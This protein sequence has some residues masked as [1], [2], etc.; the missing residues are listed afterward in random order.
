MIGRLIWRSAGRWLSLTARKSSTCPTSPS[1]LHI[2]ASK[3]AVESLKLVSYPSRGCL[4]PLRGRFTL[5]RS[6]RR[7]RK[8]LLLSLNCSLGRQY[9]QSSF[10]RVPRRALHEGEVGHDGSRLHR[11]RLTPSRRREEFLNHGL[12]DII[13]LKHQNVY[14]D[15][16]ELKD[17][18]DSGEQRVRRATQ[19]KLNSADSLPRSACTLGGNWA[20]Q[21]SLAGS[22]AHSSSSIR[23]L[24]TFLTSAERSTGPYLLLLPLHRASPSHRLRSFR[25]W[26]LR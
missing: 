8:R 16:F 6:L 19:S 14:K 9:W 4:V 21:R 2:S 18:V 22:S 17:E 3:Q 7:D 23:C 12:N 1:S 24:T 25:S 20:R 15:G 5:S 26:L 11:P 13:T 10:F